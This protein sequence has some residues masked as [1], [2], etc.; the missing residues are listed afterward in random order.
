MREG[1]R[2]FQLTNT[3]DGSSYSPRWSPDAEWI[4]FVADRGDDSQVYLINPGGGEAKKITDHEDGLGSFKWMP[5]GKQIVFTAL[6]PVSDDKKSREELYG[7]FAVDDAE[8]RMVHLWITDVD[9]EEMPEPKRLTSGTDYTVDGFNSS[10]DGDC[11][12][13]GRCRRRWKLRQL[14]L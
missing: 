10:P 5:D 13:F 7:K 6:D 2:P 4:A 3:R 11:G 12:G 14:F 1:E 8:Y 9:A